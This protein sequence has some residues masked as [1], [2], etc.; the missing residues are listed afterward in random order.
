M[1]TKPRSLAY[2]YEKF[3][4]ILLILLIV[5][6]IVQVGILWS[7][8]SGSFPISLFSNSKSPSPVSIEDSKSEYLL[9]YR[10]VLSSGFNQNHYLIA[11]GSEDYNM[12]WEGAKQ[13]I[14]QALR[15]KPKNTQIF[16]ENDWGTIVASN[17]YTFE[18]KTQIPVD[19]IKWVLNISEPKKTIG[20]GIA[21]IYKVVICPDDP[22]NNYSDILYIRDNKNIYTYDLKDSKINAL[23]ADVF[24]A[25]YT[26]QESDVNSKNYQMA[27]EMFKKF[28]ISKDLL[29]IFGD[30]RQ[31]SYADIT[32]KPIEGLAKE[33]YD[34][35][36]LNNI[37][38]ELFGNNG[39]VYDFDI[40]VNGSV[41]FKKSDGVYRLY[42][43][44]IL[45]Y[46]YRYTGNQAVTENLNV[47]SAYK[48][49]IA[50]ILEHRSQNDI[51]SNVSVYLNSIEEGQGSGSYVFNFDY[52]ISLGENKGELPV[53]LKNY[54]IPNSNSDEQLDNCISIEASSK[55]VNYFRW[56]SLKFK[57]DKSPKNY[58]WSFGNVYSEMST[59]YPE[60]KREI[61]AK[62]FGIY[63]I[64]DNKKS[65]DIPVAPSFV[66]FTKDHIYDILMKGS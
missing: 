1:K 5:L 45:E 29:G 31:E 10:V 35:K 60:L 4:A 28:E 44:S 22:N 48:K 12:L 63:Y 30:K 47:L 16:S 57:V 66:L 38:K 61:S 9:P 15:T 51:M 2:F 24:N 43:N 65:Y 50:L 37:E 58:V 8:Q 36:D 7:S 26:K 25:I 27:I 40:D 34:D 11:N 39:G 64:L 3:K 32:Y 19:I 46:R 6:C 33:E 49:A 56:L 21:G 59:F 42:K 62:D 55:N 41:V 23:N 53:L 20:E 54:Q 52:S 14:D 17:P 18:F 13:F